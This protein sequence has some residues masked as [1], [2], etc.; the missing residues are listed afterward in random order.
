[1]V[2]LRLVSTNIHEVNWRDCGEDL[3]FMICCN[4]D[5]FVCDADC[6]SLREPSLRRQAPGN[7]ENGGDLWR[8][9]EHWVTGNQIFKGRRDWNFTGIR[10]QTPAP[11]KGAFTPNISAIPSDKLSCSVILAGFNPR[12]SNFIVATTR[13]QKTNPLVGQQNKLRF[14]RPPGHSPRRLL[15]TNS[16]RPAR[17]DPQ[18]PAFHGGVFFTAPFL[19][20]A[21]ISSALMTVSRKIVVKTYCQRR[22]PAY[23]PHSIL[24]I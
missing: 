1:M 22:F 4:F 21:G 3:E 15:P 10:W 20:G 11:M 12:I 6:Y 14:C 17:R 9:R 18:R 7:G 19:A 5:C 16:A 8:I 23:N 24:D 13:H 2:R